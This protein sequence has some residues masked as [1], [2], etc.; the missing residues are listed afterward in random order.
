MAFNEDTVQ[1]IREILQ[2]KHVDFFEKRMFGGICFMVDEKICCATRIDK[3]SGT[4]L[5]LCRIS[6]TN[7][8][9]ALKRDD[10]IPMGK[11]E[12]KMKGFVF[13]TEEGF[14]SNKDLVNWIQLCIEFNPFA[15]ASKKK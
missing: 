12:N 7:Y 2:Q 9:T 4:D 15:K 6:E 1:R 13:I 14:I 10:V 8:V 5:L 3:N 11:S